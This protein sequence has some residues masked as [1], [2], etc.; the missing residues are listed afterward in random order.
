MPL[1]LLF[2]LYTYIITIK[3]VFKFNYI[4]PSRSKGTWRH[5]ILF[6]KG[7]RQIR[8]LVPCMEACIQAPNLVF[9]T[10]L[11]LIS[12]CIWWFAEVSLLHKAFPRQRSLL[13]SLFGEKMFFVYT[14]FGCS[15]ICVSIG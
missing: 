5:K 2:T 4:T 6:L 10:G 11:Y 1:I 9:Q 12:L 3:N 8:T 7:K 13:W 15:V 14:R